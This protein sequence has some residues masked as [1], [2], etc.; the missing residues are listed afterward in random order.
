MACLKCYPAENSC[1]KEPFCPPKGTVDNK[2]F[3]C[4]CGEKWVQYYPQ[5]HLWKKSSDILTYTFQPGEEV[6]SIV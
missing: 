4:E 2:K 3:T 5:F 6:K 1:K